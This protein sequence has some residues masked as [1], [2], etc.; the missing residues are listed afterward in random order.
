[1]RDAMTSDNTA[2]AYAADWRD[3][4]GW[5]DRRGLAALPASPETVALYIAAQDQA[6]RR[7]A[8][9]RRRLAAIAAQHDQHRLPAP[10]HAQVVHDAL[11]AVVEMQRL[12]PAATRTA[13]LLPGDLRRMVR[14]L[15]ATLGGLRDRALLLVGQAGV[16]RRSE[17]VAL[18]VEQVTIDGEA[19]T[20]PHLAGRSSGAR[21]SIR[22]S[23]D[24]A[25]CPVVATE[26][27]LAAAEIDRGPL[28]RP[29]DRFGRVGAER[30][31]D[32]SVALAVKRACEAAGLDPTR[33]AAGSLRSGAAIAARLGHDGG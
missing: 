3:F 4:S 27:W 23:A 5:C 31:S 26:A 24:E 6:G 32:R 17:L 25:S 1:M 30:L 15:P 14:L 7:A 11:E 2:R 13:P 28:F 21:L 29:V 8:T 20:L 12:E 9:I 10:T 22:R 33:Y 18:D 19:L 16:L